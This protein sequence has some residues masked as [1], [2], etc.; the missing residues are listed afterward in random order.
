MQPLWKPERI[1]KYIGGR[2]M[3]E[4]AEGT[5]T[6]TPSVKK[7]MRRQLL[8]ASIA[9]A[10][11]L[12]VLLAAFFYF[13]FVR[14]LY[15]Q[16]DQRLDEVI[17]YVEH[18]MD[19]DELRRCMQTGERSARY[20]AMQE[21]LNGAIDD[22]GLAYLYIVIPEADVMKN[23]ISATS[24][25]EFAAGEDNMPILEESDAY[26]QEELRRYRSF[27]DAAQTCYFEESSDYGAYYTAVKPLRTSDGA[28]LALICADE[29]IDELH[30]SMRSFLLYNIGILAA[31]CAL[32]VFVMNAWMRRKVTDPLNRLEQSVNNYAARSRDT[33]D[34]LQLRYESPDIES[35]NEV[36]SLAGAFSQM[37]DDLR[38][39]A[40]KTMEAQMRAEQIESENRR[41]AEKARTAAKIAELSASMQSLFNNIPGMA[42]SK[43]IETGRYL[44]CNRDFVKYSNKT[45]QDEVVG[46]TVQEIF[47]AEAAAQFVEDDRKTLEADGPVVFF[48]DVLDAAGK[49]RHLQTT[50][51]KFTDASGRHCILGMSTDVTEVMQMRRET[52]EAKIAYE[53]ARSSSVTYAHIAQALAAD[54]SY[55]YYVDLNDDGYIAYK[56]DGARG[57]LAVETR[58]EDFFESARRESKT[59]LYSEDVPMFLNTFRK[60]TILS[61][62]NEHGAYTLTYRQLVNGAP[63]Y[64]NMKI[65]R[66]SGEDNHIIIG[67]SNVDAQMR[68]QE[69]IERIQEERKTYERITALSGDF[70]CVY[71][72]DPETESYTQYSATREYEELGLA[73]SGVDFFA[74]AR[75]EAVHVVVPEDLGRFGNMFT[76]ENVLGEIER[77]G[78]FVLTYRML[79]DGTP[80]YVSAKAAII[81]EKDG[82]Q[83]IIGVIN[84]DAQ[85]RRE[86]EYEHNLTVART[87]ANI[88]AL[89]GVRNKHAYID[90]EAELNRRI[91]EDGAPEF[92][93]VA[94]DVN[95]LKKMNDTRGHAA[96]DQL[97]KQSC[98][99]ICRIFAHSPVFRVGGDEFTVIAQGE[100]YTNIETLLA[101]LRESNKTNKRTGGAII[102]SGMARYDGDRSV[103]TVYERADS[104]MY[105]EKRRLKSL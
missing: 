18:H 66:M 58:G 81:Q 74:R 86:I 68:Y 8:R 31:V 43:D 57:A 14:V 72:V 5:R 80:T 96:G 24:A 88:D 20:D 2:P 97:L 98:A 91:A 29:S 50:R 94:L 62:L 100:D 10:V 65:T 33:Q 11:A 42:F 15:R 71:T 56:S 102:A 37:A 13:F 87:K 76:R 40:K 79:I 55:L 77:N 21:F 99:I 53:A 92:A 3:N 34:V 60:Q 27:W 49:P 12:A 35:E 54:Y 93:I 9:F 64:M 61:A 48:E 38:A 89:T 23:V 51:L 78:V 39:S 85:M 83:L 90:A 16:Y 63:V 30:S 1:G 59:V 101:Q 84:V 6:P 47:D 26:S 103:Q 45:T 95:N 7:P 75:Q 19:A 25:A 69:A 44:A 22:L 70:I 41:L 28:T 52:R 36:Q 73:I 67:V 46:L 82:P 32:F 17:R 4:L 104:K 105:K